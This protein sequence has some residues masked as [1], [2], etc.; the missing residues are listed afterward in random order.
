MARHRHSEGDTPDVPAPQS[1]V[2]GPAATDILAPSYKEVP[3]PYVETPAA[4]DLTAETFRRELAEKEAELQRLR[5]ELLA[6]DQAKAILPNSGPGEYLVVSR[7]SPARLKKWQGHAEHEQD[8]WSKY[9]Q[10]AL[11]KAVNPKDENRRAVKSLE[12][13]IREG[14]AAGFSRTITKVKAAG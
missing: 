4:P 10:A 6:R 5:A 3:A 8:A 13:F 7:H 12:A 1:E 9:L 11:T 2:F 14:A